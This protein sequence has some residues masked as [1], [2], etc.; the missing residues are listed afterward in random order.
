M[1]LRIEKLQLKQNDSEY[2]NVI[3]QVADI[4]AACFEL[5][6]SKNAIAESLQSQYYSFFVAKQDE[7]IIG[8]MGIYYSAEEGNVTNVAVLQS[9]RRK[10]AADA[11]IAQ[12]VT[13]AIQHG[14]KEIFLEVR[15]SN[16]PAIALYEKHG[17]CHLGIRKNFYEKPKEDA[18]IMCKHLPL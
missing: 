11:L 4:E 13:D 5:P 3:K 12:A 10:G 9:H 18:C 6:W 14:V 1:E 15:K 16:T 7:Q 2:L 17:F 8:Y